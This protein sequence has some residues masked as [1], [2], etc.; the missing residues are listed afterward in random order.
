MSDDLTPDE[1]AEVVLSAVGELLNLAA[2][3]AELQMTDQAADEIYAICDLVAEYYQIERSM[4]IT[5]E[6]PDGSFTTRFETYTGTSENVVPANT[7]T[8]KGSIRTEGKPKLRLIDKDNPF[9]D[10]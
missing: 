10:E 6:H 5:E 2:S 9:K 3:V 8:N 4:P 7:N 1:V